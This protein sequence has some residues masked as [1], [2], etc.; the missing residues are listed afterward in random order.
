[1]R[2]ELKD[3][4]QVVCLD[5]FGFE[6]TFAILMR[7]DQ[8]QGWESGRSPICWSTSATS[9]RASARSS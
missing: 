8:A 2:T 1:M 9:V 3:R 6:N 5:P 4:D 7:R